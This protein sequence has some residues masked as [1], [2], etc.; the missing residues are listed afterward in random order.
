MEIRKV[1]VIGCGL[2]GSGIT[3]VCAQSG[4]N[5]VVSEI[6]NEILLKGLSSIDNLLMRNIQK[7]RIT[8]QDKDA[9][10]NRIT[11][12]ID[13]NDMATC[14]LVIEAATEN[15]DLKKEIFRSLNRICHAD[16]I[17][18]TNT[19]CLS[20]SEMA[21]ATGRQDKI[22]GLHF[23]NPVPVMKLLEIV[24]TALTSEETY[25]IGRDFGQSLGKTIVTIQDSPGFIVNRLMAP[26]I[27]SAIRL[28]E[29]GIATREDIDTAMTL[30]LNYPMGPLALADF[31]GLDTVLFIANGIYTKLPEE[32]FAA[33]SLLKT[34]VAEGLLGRKSGK[35]FYD[36][37]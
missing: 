14:D 26:Q 10:M 22:L 23:F 9:I 29:N 3:Q 28:L 11:G 21:Q 15:L 25:N 1:G 33:P 2:M 30:G 24:K 12:T 4:Y 7:E 35:G 16:T 6:N 37:T 13:I 20:V 27:L 5:V 36:Y 34:M 31:I 17:L 32:Q 19:S 18:T 8:R